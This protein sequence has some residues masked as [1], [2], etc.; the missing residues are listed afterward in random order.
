MYQ[1]LALITPLITAPY[2]SRVLGV[3]QIGIYSRTLANQ[4]FF[5]LL[6]GL[7]TASY[8]LREIARNRDDAQ[9]RS[10]LFWEIELL[11]VGTTLVMLGAWA[12]WIF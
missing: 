7:G 1:V 8:G 5:S 10:K 2:V 3:D 9:A 4:Y 11:T 12:V 6:A